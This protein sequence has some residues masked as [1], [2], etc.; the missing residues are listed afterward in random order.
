[1]TPLVKFSL[2]ETVSG[3]GKISMKKEYSYP[4]K[5]CLVLTI[6]NEVCPE[7]LT[8]MTQ[9]LVVSGTPSTCKYC[10]NLMRLHREFSRGITVV[11]LRCTV[12][13]H[14]KPA[15]LLEDVDED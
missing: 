7:V 3:S 15:S 8:L 6:C 1:M 14:T 4:C 12:C 11:S 5:D 10:G 2:E 9:G 13:I